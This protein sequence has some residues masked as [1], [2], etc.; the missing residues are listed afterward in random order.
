[1]KTY[2]K[3]VRN[4]I[5]YIINESGKECEWVEVDNKEDQENLIKLKLIEEM[6]EL[7]LATTKEVQIEEI[8]DIMEVLD[9][10]MKVYGLDK[11]DVE[12]KKLHKKEE[13]GGFDNFVVLQTVM[14]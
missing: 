7:S 6:T 13:R 5:P 14:D 12:F 9:A 2:N 3:L 8:A 4:K 11:M 10:Y 1:M